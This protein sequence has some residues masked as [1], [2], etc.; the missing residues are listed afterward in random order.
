MLKF[1]TRVS[2]LTFIIASA[3]WGNPGMG[4]LQ[5]AGE[6]P[7]KG[8][9]AETM[10]SGGYTYLKLK[11]ASG[12]IWAAVSQTPV[13]VGADAVIENP[14]IMNGFESKTLKRK[15]DKIVFGSLA[16]AAEPSPSQKGQPSGPKVPSFGASGMSQPHGTPAEKIN[17][18]DIK[19]PKAQGSNGKTVAE[20]YSQKA[21]L[22]GK[23]VSVRGKVTK[24]SFGIMGKNWL[25][26]SDGTGKVEE[27]NF[28]LT[29]ST[30]AK[31]QVGDV[32]LVT[33]KLSTDR[34][35]GAGY[36]YPVIIEDAKV[37]K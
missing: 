23:E 16:G 22:K 12:D 11:T 32:V 26:I 20:I 14:M 1:V 9:I 33:G 27:K 7:V 35:I 34:D 10:D 13:K 30:G 2:L 15:F 19:V 24:A 5:Q 25:H 8:K 31:A 36:F 18:S 3:A 37:E 21:A 29:V 4:K 6:A 28:D 17:L